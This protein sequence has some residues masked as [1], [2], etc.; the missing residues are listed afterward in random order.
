MTQKEVERATVL[1]KQL[2]SCRES[3]EAIKNTNTVKLVGDTGKVIGK[4]QADQHFTDL[5]TDVEAGIINELNELGVELD[6]DN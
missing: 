6:G 3:A 2:K 5:I 1:L 4:F